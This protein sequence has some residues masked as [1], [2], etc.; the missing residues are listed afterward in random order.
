[1]TVAILSTFLT[2]GQDL[3]KAMLSGDLETIQTFV[4]SGKS[5]DEPHV[6]G[7]Y[8]L[9]CAAIKS[10]SIEIVDYLLKKGAS[11]E[12][13][14]NGKTPLMY[15]AKYDRIEI[16]KKLVAAGADVNARHSR[17]ST[18]LDYAKRYENQDL[19]DYLSK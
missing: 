9:L 7:E 2:F 6:D 12:M 17:G 5:I 4:N 18:A 10:G 11:T 15:A 13:K 3:K 16:A 19:V 8:T 1:M 14:T